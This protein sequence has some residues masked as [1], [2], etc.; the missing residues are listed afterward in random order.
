MKSWTTRE[1]PIRNWPTAPESKAGWACR[2]KPV[3]QTDQ[4]N[5]IFDVAPKHYSL[6]VADENDN[7]MYIDIPLNL[8]TEMPESKKI[9]G[10]V[11][12]VPVK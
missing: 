8:T 2:A 10:V 12:V 11:P 4:G 6:R 1:I 5:I 3:A 9:E 7:F